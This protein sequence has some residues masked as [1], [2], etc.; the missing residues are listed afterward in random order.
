MSTPS[1]LSEQILALP[2]GA[3]AVQ[4]AG[5]TFNISPY[6]GTGTYE[7][8][9][10]VPAGHAGIKHPLS[11]TYSTHGGNGIAGLGWSLSIAA[12]R[13]RTDK[14]I[15]S[16]DDA[17]DVFTLEGDELL[18]TGAGSYRQR[19]ERRFA[20]IRHIRTGGRD[21]WAVTDRDGRRVLYGVEPDHRLHDGAGHIASWYMS[22]VQDTNGNEVRFSYTRDVATND[23]RVSAIEWAGCYRVRFSYEARP[24]PIVTVRPGFEYRQE[25][26]L[27]SIDVAVRRSS[28]NE[29]ATY[30]TY[31]L[32]YSL[33][34]VTGRSLLASVAITG[35]KRD[36]SRHELPAVTFGYAQPDLAQKKWRTLSGALPG[37]SLKDRNLTLVRQSGSGL[38]D[39][40]ETAHSGHWLRTNLGN[41]TFGSAVRVSSPS[42]VLLE[43]VGTFISDMSGHGWGDLVVN[44]GQQVYRAAAGGGWTLPYISSQ[45]PSIDLEAPDVRLADY[46]GD[47]VPDALRAGSGPWVYFEN[48]RNGQWAPGRAIQSPPPVRFDD[49]HVHLADINGDGIPDL[50]YMDRRRVRVWLGEGFGRF[51]SPFE[52]RHAPDFGEAF[53]PKAVRWTDMTGSGQADLLYVRNGEV[54]ICFNQGGVVLSDPVT[55]RGVPQSPHG[56]IEPVDLLGTGAAGL[57]FSDY[58]VR[59]GT[60]RYLELF[61]DGQPDLLTSIDNGLGAISTIE[62]ATS[63]RDWTADKRAGK[64]WRTAMP[65]HQVVV[66]GLTTLDT[67]TANRLGTTYRYHD[68]VYD[69][70]EREFRGFAMVEQIDREAPAGDPQ[71][72]PQ[73]LVKR[74]YHTGFDVQLRDQYTALPSGAL[75]DEVPELPSAFR[76]LRGLIRREETFAL[77]GNPRPYLVSETAYQVI[78]VQRTPGTAHYSFATLPVMARSTYT[79][80]TDERRISETFTT[81][82]LQEGSGYGLP[83]EFRE[84]AFARVGD[85]VDPGQ[86]VDLERVT[87]TAYVNL[88]EPD[89]DYL[90][91]Y[92]P[93]YLAGK[94]A[95]IE[96]FAVTLSGEVL[97]DRKRQFYDGQEYS[98]LGYPGTGT[99]AGVSRGRLSSKLSLAFTAGSVAAAYPASSTAREHLEAR[100]RFLLDGEDYYIHAERYKYDER[101]M[102][103][104][105]L[106]PNG[107]ETS[108]EYDSTFGLFPVRTTD[109]AGHPTLL[110]RGEFPYQV[111]YVVDSNGNTTSFTYDPSGLVES[112]SVQG[113]YDGND[114][115]GDPPSDPT[116]TYSYDFSARPVKIVTRTRQ[117]RLGATLDTIHYIDSLGRDVQQVQT[118]EPDP[119]TGAARYRVSAWKVFNH[120]GLIVRTYQPAFAS[121]DEYE[122]GAKSSA[123]IETL[124]DPLGRSTR[125]NQPDRTYETTTYHPWVRVFADRNDNSGH[126]DSS[127]P[128]YGRFLADLRT[129][130]GT[131]ARTFV[132]AFGRD[133][134]VAEDNGGE[135][136]TTHKTLDLNSRVVEVRDP[137]GLAGPTWSFAFDLAGRP[138]YENHSTATGGRYTLSDAAGNPIWALDARGITT[139]RAF[140]ALNRPLETTTDDGSGPKLRRQ[141]RYIEYDESSSDFATNQAKNL[142]GRVEEE[143]DADGLR[144]FEYD[145]RGLVVKTTYRF[146]MQ[147]WED[148]AAAMWTQGAAWDPP[149]PDADRQ[150]I[151]FLPLPG[152]PAMETTAT[153]D[154]ASRPIQTVYPEGMTTLTSYNAAGLLQSLSVDRGEGDGV[155]T[156]VESFEYNAR[157]QQ[158]T[159]LHGNGILTTRGYDT[160]LERITRIFTRMDGASPV[161]FQ[162]L[163]YTYDPVGN[164][165]EVADNLAGSQFSHNRIIPNTRTFSYDPRYRLIKATGKKHAGVRRREDSLVVP[166]PDPNDYEPY[167]FRYSYDAVGNAVRN[168]EYASGRLNY[169]PDRADLFDGSQ[170]ELGNFVY[171]AAGNTIH[172]PRQQEL[173]Y[174]HDSQVRYA[175]LNGG[176][177]IW[178]LRHGNQRVVRLIRKNGVAALSVYVG[179]F[180]Y[181]LRKGTRSYTKLVLQL[182][183]HDRHAQVE[184]VLAG[185]D[186]RGLDLF[187]HHSDHLG[188][189]HVLTTEDGDLLNQEENF[190][191]G[192]ISD[193]RDS[194]N[195]YRFIGVERD[196]DTHL[197]MTGPR[198]YDPAIGR[199][200]QPDPIAGSTPN[201]SPFVY[202]GAS[203]LVLRDPEGF[204]NTFTPDGKTPDPDEPLNEGDLD[205]IW[206]R[207]S[208]YVYVDDHC[209]GHPPVRTE[210]QRQQLA[211]S[212]TWFRGG[213]LETW[214]EPHLADLARKDA[215]RDAAFYDE[216]AD[217]I[218]TVDYLRTG[219]GTMTEDQE[220][221]AARAEQVAK[222]IQ[223]GV[224]IEHQAR[225]AGAAGDAALQAGVRAVEGTALNDAVRHAFAGIPLIGLIFAAQTVADAKQAWDKGDYGMAGV[226][227]I[228]LVVEPAQWALGVT[229]LWDAWNQYK[230]EQT[231]D[232]IMA[233]LRRIEARET[234]QPVV[235][236]KDDP[237]PSCHY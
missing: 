60:W 202:S 102:T 76:S 171:D 78:P 236:V 151:E 25:H 221:L 10:D 14:A 93:T 232:S 91:P 1:N 144:F 100:G 54:T 190:P 23:V 184:R 134:A 137:R 219:G 122:P 63:A 207:L 155:Q 235:P 223:T 115:N 15:P 96:R 8:A 16:Y 66:V 188:S 186:P 198:T 38:P 82:D 105:G 21:F 20:R 183:G 227:A 192:G 88:D 28:N 77:D 62:Y 154:A 111:E 72:L 74:W 148:A 132:D 141:W 33:S 87:R 79:E 180:E 128:R 2:N 197:C 125:V 211:E 12:I 99:E 49:T 147:T 187:F 139:I 71:P 94:P 92:V 158:T 69:D 174:T 11:L 109:P 50:I 51:G 229:S 173:A 39:L 178:Y 4:S 7:I 231:S 228:S 143:R 35:I 138:V 118:A 224:V 237:C 121:S 163:A 200:L 17:R 177:Q 13:R 185:S 90:A 104:G 234:G 165:V 73:V 112:K 210:I 48:M 193:R 52:L 27:A 157:G 40:F 169:Q 22:K 30:R 167:V 34:S 150:A 196:E 70:V 225:I 149:I 114:W 153:Y 106:D 32:K 6:N 218:A 116:E 46:S 123:F 31:R 56:H 36:G 156:V 170:D 212:V 65:S 86:A 226:Q 81:Y 175:D 208:E 130:V 179:P 119:E 26:R 97:L 68:G 135:L 3:G 108:F 61:P 206:G 230:A 110:T 47:G 53:D 126:I 127:D 83:T 195:R 59:P 101:G 160:D 216:A 142:F 120:K 85:S 37:G 140:D 131:P 133:V 213:E 199:F 161:Y 145:W 58:Q 75:T 146:W 9:I 129:H 103:T 233:E 201:I 117:V 214:G 162:D 152:L 84:K 95:R 168:P 204:G 182:E 64:P 107:N 41:A 43:Q 136:H 209:G 191:Y 98:G 181:Y 19:I 18:P 203:P 89:G 67:I 80:R 176:G 166:S 159:C 42:R 164:L 29:F 5:Q 215:L 222:E 124:Y 55:L 113:K 172:T 194:R 44:G 24:D 45:A 205:D 220:R 57:L 189:G 217:I